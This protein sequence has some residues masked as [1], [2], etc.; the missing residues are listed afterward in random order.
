MLPAQLRDQKASTQG[1]LTSCR[2]IGAAGL[3]TD[4]DSGRCPAAGTKLPFQKMPMMLKIK[5]EH[6]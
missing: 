3:F 6:V 4:A 5:H 2:A 1:L